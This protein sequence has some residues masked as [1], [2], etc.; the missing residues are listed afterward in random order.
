MTVNVGDKIVTKKPHPCGCSEWT[1]LRVGA[2]IKI[3]C[4]KC[5]RIVMLSLSD[6]KKRLKRVNDA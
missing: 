5:S 3:K 1:V 4:D 6:F 2:D